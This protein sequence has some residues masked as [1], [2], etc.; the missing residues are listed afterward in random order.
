MLTDKRQQDLA[1][2]MY[3][4]AKTVD[5]TRLVS[6]ND[7]WENVMPTD[8]VTI[9]DYAYDDSEFQKNYVDTDV[10]ALN[11]AGRK[12]ISEGNEYSGQ[13]IIFSEFGGIAMKSNSGDENWG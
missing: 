4:I 12:V 9:H 2:A 7:G 10:N 11:P 5:G 13:P 1:R 8:L 6:S 3:Y